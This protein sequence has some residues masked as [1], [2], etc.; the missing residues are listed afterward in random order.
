M[1][2]TGSGSW[3]QRSVEARRAR[4]YWIRPAWAARQVRARLS[5][6]MVSMWEAIS[7]ATL[8]GVLVLGG[9]AEGEG[10]A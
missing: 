1:G 5:R 8:G 4:R 10:E 9:R 6:V 3:W 2:S 7:T